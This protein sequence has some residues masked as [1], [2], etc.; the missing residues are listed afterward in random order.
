MAAAIS[1]WLFHGAEKVLASLS[2]A[3]LLADIDLLLQ[4][5]IARA[6]LICPFA[7]VRQL[8]G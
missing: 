8:T 5:W 2:A 4:E 3:L 7:R 1:V 6:F